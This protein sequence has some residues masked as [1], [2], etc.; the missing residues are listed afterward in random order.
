MKALKVL[1]GIVALVVLAAGGFVAY[2]FTAYPRVGPAE[3]VTVEATPARIARGDYL[4][5]H[6]T[7]C[8]ECHARRDFTKSAGPR[9][10]GTAGQGGDYFGEP[11]SA[12]ELYSPN[13]TPA[14]LGDWTDGEVIRAF[15]EGV[16]KDGTP[17]FPIMPYL[18]YGKLARE[19]VEA[20]VAYIRTLPPSDY[21]PPPSHLGFPLPLVKRTIPT[22]AAF[23]PVP[24]VED[25]VAYGEYLINAAVCG[26]C[27]TTMDDQGQALP[28]MDYAGGNEFYIPGGARVR[29]AN[30]TPDADTGIGT[31]SEADF[32]Q[33]F[34]AYLAE[35]PRV[36]TAEE[37]RENTIMPW[38]AYA[39]MTE[40]DLGA[41]YTYLRTIKPVVNRVDTHPKP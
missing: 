28:G 19:D 10:E 4:A 30:I 22:P 15:T 24:P 9:I 13:I 17:L 36:L 35:P 5:N 39:G 2:L 32:I 33:K 7:G 40:Q 16:S 29:T 20:I 34:K 14:R 38:Y 25:R 26:D 18:R 41:I 23:R 8:V 12:L 6:V 27:H 3:A 21:Q 37:Q 1:V 31:W 11:G